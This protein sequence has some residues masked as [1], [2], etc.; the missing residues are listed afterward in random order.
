[1]QTYAK[2]VKRCGRGSRLSREATTGMS[3]SMPFPR[4][5][6]LQSYARCMLKS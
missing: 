2:L 4:L 3:G 5:H 1:M 6:L